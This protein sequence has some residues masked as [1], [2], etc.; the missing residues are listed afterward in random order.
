M[1]RLFSILSVLHVPKNYKCFTLGRKRRHRVAVVEVRIRADTLA[2]E[3][4]T[5][6]ETRLAKLTANTLVKTTMYTQ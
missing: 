3:R 2:N 1:C 5:R 6:S 4:V